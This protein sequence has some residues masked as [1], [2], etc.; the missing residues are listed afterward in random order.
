MKHS[1]GLMSGALPLLYP[2]FVHC[3]VPVL[4]RYMVY[5]HGDTFGLCICNLLLQ[6]IKILE[7]DLIFTFD[8]LSLSRVWMVWVHCPVFKRLRKTTS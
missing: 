2:S 6:L 7:T 5:I 8:F 4:K 3:G 1:G